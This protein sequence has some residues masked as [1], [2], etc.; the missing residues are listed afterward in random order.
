MLVIL[1]HE[2]VPDQQLPSAFNARWLTPG[3]RIPFETVFPSQ[4]TF[5]ISTYACCFSKLHRQLKLLALALFAYDP[6][7]TRVT[8]RLTVVPI[9][10]ASP[11]SEP[12][13]FSP[14]LHQQILCLT[15]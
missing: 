11:Q 4:S 7:F 3:S 2:C 6:H 13:C 1:Q 5:L 9:R 10:P 15:F 8:S 12:A 14:A